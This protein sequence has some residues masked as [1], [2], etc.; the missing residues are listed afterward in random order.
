MRVSQFIPYEVFDTPAGIEPL[1]HYLELGNLGL[2]K[3]KINKIINALDDNWTK[4]VH[5]GIH[6]GKHGI[7]TFEEMSGYA[8]KEVVK[9]DSEYICDMKRI[10][11]L[12]GTFGI[13]TRACSRDEMEEV[14]YGDYSKPIV[15]KSTFTEIRKSGKRNIPKVMTSI[16]FHIYIPGP[17]TE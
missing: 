1:Y 6:I 14:C 3:K 15:T 4:C 5:V 13:G 10:H 11:V 12:L 17:E 16:A 8:Y 9:H 2:S 7:P